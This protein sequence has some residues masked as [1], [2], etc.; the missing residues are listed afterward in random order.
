MFNFEIC[1][2]KWKNIEESRVFGKKQRDM[3]IKKL[4]QGNIEKDY[5]LVGIIV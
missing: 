1:F 3:V 2:F 5:M 4:L